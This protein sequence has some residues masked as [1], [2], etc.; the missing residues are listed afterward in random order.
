[1]LAVAKNPY[2]EPIQKFFQELKETKWQFPF[3][4]QAIHAIISLF[5]LVILLFLYV[6]VGIVSQISNS[7]WDVIDDLGDK[8]SFSNPFPSLFYAISATIYFAIFLPFFILQSPIW[9]SGWITSKIGFRPFIIIIFTIII[10]GL[11][12]YYQ[13]QVALDAVDN[14]IAFQDS[15]RDEYFSSDSTQIINANVS[16]LPTK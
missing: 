3:L 9:L 13:P 1:M 15:I 12:Y 16:T 11:L 7:F 8:M 6:T 14:L 4:L 2:G 5:L 10:T